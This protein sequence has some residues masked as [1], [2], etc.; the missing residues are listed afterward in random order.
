MKPEK[1][2]WSLSLD[3]SCPKCSHEFDILDDTEFISDNKLE[4]CEHGTQRSMGIN[5]MCPNCDSEFKVDLAY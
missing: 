2:I 3:C 5:V 1:A 4:V